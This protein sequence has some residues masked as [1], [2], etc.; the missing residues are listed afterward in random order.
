MGK[1]IMS[2]IV[3][4]LVVP[5]KPGI[6]ASELAV[7]STVKLMEN[8]TAVEYLVVNQ[9][10]PDNS[11]LYDSSCDGTWLLRKD[12]VANRTWNDS[13]SNSYKDSTMHSYLNSTFL[14]I[15]EDSSRVAIKPVK[16]PYL[17]G[18][19]VSGDAIAT[20]A[21][22]LETSAFLLGSYELGWTT[23]GM[24]Y[25]HIDGACL[26]YFNGAAASDAKRIANWNGV[27]TNWWLRTATGNTQDSVIVTTASGGRSNMKYSYSNGVRPCVIIDRTALFDEETLVLKGVA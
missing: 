26:S 17:N 16:I 4:Q 18:M 5:R 12:C 8:G 22:G 10:I 3:P 23:Y 24:S 7:G 25:M 15:F 27:V 1:V 19:G 9:G 13:S 11:S 14:N 2:G 21:N 6:Q 20:G